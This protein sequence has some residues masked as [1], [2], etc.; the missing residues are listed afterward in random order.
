M[1][2]VLTILTALALLLASLCVGVFTADLPFW[3]R[4]YDLPLAPGEAYSPT[5]SVHADA[6]TGTGMVDGSLI[7][8]DRAALEEA[9]ERARLTGADAILVMHGTRLQTARHFSTES[10]ELAD[11]RMGPADFLARPLA[12]LA[13]GV[14]IG[15]GLIG[16]LDEPVA[17]WLHEWEGEARGRITLR[18]LLNETSGLET[19][20]DAADVLGS[21]PFAD[22]ERLPRFATSR[23]VRL[24]LGNDF[25]STALGFRLDHEPGGFFNVS[26]ANVQL[27]AI[28]LERAT[29]MQYERY[30]GDRVLTDVISG[31]VQMQM[32]RRSGMP[33]AHCC[34]MASPNVALTLA[35]RLMAAM[36]PGGGLSLGKSRIAP[37]WIDEMRRGSRANPEFGLQ[38][39]RLANVDLEVWR[40]GNGR[41]GGAWIAPAAGLVV[42]V[43]ARR[44]APTPDEIVEP[45]L[46]AVRK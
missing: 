10:R 18:Q 36:D 32:D 39:E 6:R 1:R 44:D 16:S 25:E 19:G 8:L 17:T 13:L 20:V 5:V 41:G 46:A 15:E 31:D 11:G 30:V 26:P 7:D 27:V 12:A 29:G 21:R 40:L 42:V 9:S 34:L 3:Q 33:A 35:N 24:L 28:I 4:A 45:L 14:A 22:W 37:R 43:T 2:R 23:G 38:M